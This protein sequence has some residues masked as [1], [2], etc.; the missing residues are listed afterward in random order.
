MNQKTVIT[1]SA[2]YVITFMATACITSYISLYYS[3][4][5]LNNT[6]IGIINAVMAA[7]AIFSQPLFGTIS[8]KSERKNVILKI[9][10]LLSALT[11]WLIPL[12]KHEFLAILAATAI[13]S[14]FHS[15]VNPLSDTIAINLANS[16]GFMFSRVRMF[17]SLGF[18]IMSAAAA[19]VFSSNIGLIF[20]A[21]FVFRLLGYAMSFLLPTVH[22]YKNSVN[23][24]SFMD[25]FKDKKLVIIYV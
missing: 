21:Y 1:V 5:G 23:Q 4:I 16:G 13:F 17:G 15:T 20:T 2:Y 10:I 3:D 19:K 7:V 18:A 22:G 12:A 24:P 11:T 9:V 14:F 6:Q 8:D 25:L